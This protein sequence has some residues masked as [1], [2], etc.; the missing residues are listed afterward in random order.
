MVQNPAVETETLADL[1]HRRAVNASTSRLAIEF[2][3]G[4]L[5]TLAA[6]LLPATARILVACF[7]VCLAMSA[8]W[9]TAEAQIAAPQGSRVPLAA[10]RAMRAAATLTGVAAALTL[11]FVSIAASLG[12][13]I[14]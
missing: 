6:Q 9:S 8:L 5:L 3:A 13:W 2:N 14:S 10:W 11:V 4:A 1:L 12:T 7:G